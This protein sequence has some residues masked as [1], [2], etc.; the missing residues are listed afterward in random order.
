MA[1]EAPQNPVPSEPVAAAAPAEVA[2]DAPAKK[3]KQKKEKPAK[4]AKSQQPQVPERKAPIVDDYKTAEFGDLVMIQSSYKS[5]RDW[6]EISEI[7]T[8]KIGQEVWIRARLATTRAPGKF[9]FV[10]LRRG[11]HTIQAVA[12]S[13]EGPGNV[14]RDCVKF[15][16]K[17]PTESVVD[18]FGVLSKPEQP[19][20]SAS[21]SDVEIQIRKMFV[22]SAA[23]PVLPFQLSDASQP[24]EFGADAHG[25][26]NEEVEEKSS[27]EAKE[28][29]G[30]ITVTQK[31]RLDNRWIDLRT[32]ANHAIF[33]LQSR[34]CQFYRAY[35]TNEGFVEIHTPKI[36]PGVSEG[37]ANVFKLKYFNQDACLAQS[38]QLY[39]QMAVVS[40]L[41][42]V[43]EIG[44]VF[45][46]EDSNT[47]RHMCEFI[48][49]DFEMEIKEHYH[50]I[51]KVLGDM[52]ISV[53]DN[54]NKHCQAELAAVN[55]QYAFEP[56]MYKKETLILS[57]AE[58]VALL[59]EAGEQ[60]GDFDDFSTPQEKKLGRIVKEKYQTEFYIVDRY[61]LSVRPF[62]TM[63]CSDDARYSNSYDVF[64]RGE[65]I[66]SGAQRV[67]DVELLKKR[68]E[69]CGI[70]MDNI[71]KYVES[72]K[73][74][75]FP[76]GGA[77]IGLERVVMLF[78]GLDNI[79]KTSMFPRT[80]NRLEP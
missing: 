77:G 32:P 23:F 49:M 59:R 41:F 7:N 69:A 22:V 24:V 29:G 5:G 64:L 73:Y 58:A 26:Q 38:P 53:F 10:M 9:A 37:G 74:G 57:F 55:K 30:V 42:K 12:S 66:T 6:Q 2:T 40:D 20:A 62:Y 16:G 65:E 52:F 25:D 21:I 79:R 15:I 67:H 63:P 14:S 78:L 76:H 46:A 75:A 80:P 54:I 28:K 4:P 33:R 61:P 3:Q 35:F 13:L 45:R 11:F 51:L 70:P 44:H 43:F 50:E 72:F 68:A 8:E 17:I 48:G 36:T 71:A 31:S 60:M 47:H 1:S 27:K 34:I 39:K 56:L 18:I 19:V